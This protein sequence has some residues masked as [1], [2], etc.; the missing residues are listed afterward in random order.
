HAPEVSRSHN[1]AVTIEQSGFDPETIAISR[2]LA[3]RVFDGGVTCRGGSVE[4]PRRVGEVAGA[5]DVVAFEHRA[6]AVSGHLIAPRSGIPAR[7]KLRTA[8]RRKSCAM[9][10]RVTFLVLGSLVAGPAASSA[11]RPTRS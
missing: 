11:V 7:T 8:V 1:H 2:D 9:R 10:E 6:G 5:H 3:R 4:P